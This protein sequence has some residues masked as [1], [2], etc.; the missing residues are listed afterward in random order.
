M[1]RD[2]S[3]GKENFSLKSN[4]KILYPKW[5]LCTRERKADNTD[6]PKGNVCLRHA[7]TQTANV[8]EVFKV[9]ELRETVEETK[10]LME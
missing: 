8:T 9:N 10:K 5:K 1:K 3:L 4:K 2:S 7:R 6:D